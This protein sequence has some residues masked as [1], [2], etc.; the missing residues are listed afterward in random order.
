MEA[1]YHLKPDLPHEMNRDFNV[2]VSDFRPG[3]SCIKFDGPSVGIE[4]VQ[5]EVSR[6][7]KNLLMNEI[8]LEQECQLDQLEQLRKYHLANGNQVYVSCPSDQIS[9]KVVS[10]WSFNPNILRQAVT[11]VRRQLTINSTFLHCSPEEAIFFK[12][13]NQGC[14]PKLS[15]HVTFNGEKVSLSGTNE[16]VDASKEYLHNNLFKGLHSKK[17]T[18]LCSMKFKSHIEQSLLRPQC[19]E[20]PSFK[21]LISDSPGNVKRERTSRKVSHGR[22]EGKDE[23]YVYIFCRNHEFF[24]KICSTLDGLSPGSKPYPIFH[25]GTDKIVMEMMPHLENKYNVRIIDNKTSSYSIMGL[26][27]AE[28]HQCY[29]EIKQ[30]VESKLVTSKHIPIT[31]QMYTVLKKLCQAEV[32]EL[33]SSC[34]EISIWPQNKDHESS[35]IRV[36]GSISQVSDVHSRLK[37]GLLSMDVYEEHCELACPTY[38]FVMWCRR[39]N[40]IVEEELKRSKT[41]V[42]FNKDSEVTQ[43]NKLNIRFH[44]IGTDQVVVQEVKQAIMSEGVETEEKVITLSHEGIMCLFKARKDKKMSE[45]VKVNVFVINIDKQYKKATLIS[46]KELSDDFLETAEEQIRTYVGDRAST[47]H[48]VCSKDPVVS[49]ILSFPQRSISFTTHANAIA[50]QH[51]V[52]VTIQKKPNVGL[53]LSGIESAIGI[54]KPLIITAVLGSIEKTIGQTQVSFKYIYAPLLTTPE[55]SRFETKLGS[56]LC[57]TCS[58][59]KAGKVSKLICS[60]LLDMET[61]GKSVKI[62]ICL[63]DIVLEQVDA[64]VNAANEDL[65]HIGGLAKAICDMGGPNIQE[66]SNSYIAEHKKLNAGRAVCLGSG[67]LPCKRVVHAVGP[68]W[69]GGVQNEEQLLYFAILES[70]KCASNESLTSIA[71]PAIGTGIFMVPEVVCARASL[72]AV[73]D[74]CQAHSETSV[75]S[76]KF[77]LYK[78]S[79]VDVFKPLLQSGIC[80]KYHIP[81]GLTSEVTPPNPPT[82]STTS[83]TWQWQN[84][85]GLFSPYSST[86]SSQ[87]TSAYIANS[88]GTTQVQINNTAYIIDFLKMKQVNSQTLASRT[89]RHIPSVPAKSSTPSVE[90]L[91]NEGGVYV[92]YAP[93]QCVE[94]EKMYQDGKPGQLV[95][96]GNSYIIDPAKMCQ[97]NS[98]TSFQRNIDRR[99]QPVITAMPLLKHVLVDEGEKVVRVKDDTVITLR[100]PHDCLHVAEERLKKKMRDSVVKKCF[101]KLPKVMTSELE[102]KLGEIAHTNIV[103]WSFSDT[104]T[105]DGKPQRVMNLEGVFFKHQAAVNAIQE[106]ILNFHLSSGSE[107][108]LTYPIDWQAQTKT[109]ELFPLQDGST[110]WNRVQAKFSSTMQVHKLVDISRIQN[111]WLWERYA[112]QKKRMD[113]KNNGCVNE[114][115]LFHG[116]RS[117]DPKIIYEGEDGFDMRYGTQG[118]WGV[119][120]YFAVKASYSHDY[121]HTSHAGNQMFLA[122][123]LT[124]DSHQCPS[125]RSLRMPPNKN[126]ASPS[127]DLQL[128]QMKYDTVTGHTNGSQVFMTYDNDKAYPAY[129]ITYN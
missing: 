116:T 125:D 94:I 44:I 124:G 76:I 3:S 78:N 61:S 12:S 86:V 122:N 113:R 65:K 81:S 102:K 14:L 117:N 21:Y 5:P 73:R 25:R 51:Q 80:G 1:L 85:Q 83:A 50:K 100:G 41:S 87:L 29:D 17:Y 106:E 20:E 77:I 22:N 7:V 37:S 18:L 15:A 109:T 126:T 74:F 40:Q 28:I 99:V 104:T 82:S 98:T 39:W 70:L 10:V 24:S 9:R 114:M 66:E 56:D 8:C 108:N 42:T 60:S 38:L 16:Q 62:D 69:K 97:V 13:F 53:R 93:Q 45:I 4:K 47:S 88:R 52:S 23:L 34:G 46:P 95:I 96:N 120:N 48:V 92:P 49:L 127:G 2:I 6:L 119:A 123:V 64:I 105:K 72:K 68:Q 79:S 27:S 84:D 31:N 121:R 101:D 59:P 111:Q 32:A 11:I 115:E 71:F 26:T 90:W 63:G 128:L 30:N 112:A 43:D 19:E 103:D 91:Y 107:E 67:D 33:K 54:V 129:L 55:F 118:M 57:V 58:F 89:V 36:S 35:V 110:E 75:V